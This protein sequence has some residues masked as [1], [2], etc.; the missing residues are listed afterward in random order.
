MLFYCL[1]LTHVFSVLFASSLTTM[2][3]NLWTP[4]L[5]LRPILFLTVVFAFSAPD[6][7][8][9]ANMLCLDLFQSQNSRG[10]YSI[11]PTFNKRQASLIRGV[12]G[13]LKKLAA[14]V[15]IPNPDIGKRAENVLKSGYR[16]LGNKVWMGMSSDNFYLRKAIVVL[17][18]EFGHAIFD[19]NIYFNFQGRRV[20]AL[21]GASIIEAYRQ[22]ILSSPEYK[23]AVEEMKEKFKRFTKERQER[24]AHAIFLK[25]GG[26]EYYKIFNHGEDLSNIVIAHN[27]LFADMIAVMLTRDGDAVA[28]VFKSQHPDSMEDFSR[29]FLSITPVENFSLSLIGETKYELLNPTRTFIW[30]RYLAKLSPEFYQKFIKAYLNATQ[31]H[32]ETL[33]ASG[34]SVR[35]L[36]LYPKPQERN[37]DFIKFL[38]IELAKQGIP[39]SN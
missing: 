25:L 26:D 2:R 33:I 28:N 4:F 7:Q 13:R 11:D 16:A 39:Q 29:S 32:L 36:A 10:E 20:N 12:I 24:E 18:H 30:T 6:Q 1:K 37:V 15:R 27:E 14:E 19:L 8:A 35:D 21:E 23:T 22:R 31:A 17:A 3:I 9:Q 5:K 38:E 34:E